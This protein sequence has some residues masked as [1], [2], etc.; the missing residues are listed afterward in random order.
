[1]FR[2]ILLVSALLVPGVPC[3][4]V[5]DYSRSQIS[6][7]SRQMNVPVETAFKKFTAQ[8]AFNP[9]RPE[10]SKAR[11]DV[12]LNSLDL[13]DPEMAETLRD[14]NWFDT[15]NHPAAVFT[16]TSVRALGGG[17]YEVRGPLSMKGRTQEV[18][19][20]FIVRMSGAGRILEGA[21]P[22]RR[23]QYNV[24]DAQWRDTSVVADEVQIRFRLYQTTAKPPLPG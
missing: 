16:S 15:K 23:L 22:I 20:S 14:R 9:E 2:A 17:R 24:G 13:A 18:A 19:A 7:V 6:I 11:I 12:D 1:M 21:F 5:I 10:A 8:I 4:Q 3:A